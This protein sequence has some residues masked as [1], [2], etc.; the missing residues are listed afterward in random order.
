MEE[1][2]LFKITPYEEIYFDYLLKNP[3]N[4]WLHDP[5]IRMSEAEAR[6]MALE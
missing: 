5:V 3:K 4:P 1:N 2:A 6:Y